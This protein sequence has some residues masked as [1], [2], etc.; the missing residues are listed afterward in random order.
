MQFISLIKQRYPVA[1]HA[2]IP[3]HQQALSFLIY[4]DNHHKGENK[5]EEGAAHLLP[6]VEHQSEQQAK[7]TEIFPL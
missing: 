4:R 5:E 2:V 3:D 7:A 6:Q 1:A